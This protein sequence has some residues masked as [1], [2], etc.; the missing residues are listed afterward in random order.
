MKIAGNG[1][2][3]LLLR[4]VLDSSVLISAILSPS[5]SSGRGWTAA[6]QKRF[7][8]VTSPFIVAEVAR[9]LRRR[10]LWGEEQIV[11][12]LKQISRAAD[13]IQPATFLQIVRDPEDNPILECA[14][15]GNAD[16]IVSLDKDLLTLKAYD[17]I[18]IL[19]VADLLVTLGE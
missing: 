9:F 5:G 2:K 14:V 3:R 18:P 1:E 6:R 12:R 10:S 8:L 7:Q 15:D 16:M 4:V 11:R 13:I 17:N 19:H